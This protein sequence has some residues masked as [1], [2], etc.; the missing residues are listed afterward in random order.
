MA[1]LNVNSDATINGTLTLKDSKGT[2]D[3]NTLLRSISSR[4][5]LAWKFAGSVSNLTA[6]ADVMPIPNG[7]KGY[8]ISEF[9][10][11]TASTTTDNYARRSIVI[12]N[13]YDVIKDGA[14]FKFGTS[15]S[16]I[17]ISLTSSD[18]GSVIRLQGYRINGATVPCKVFVYYR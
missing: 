8:T 12:P 1:A 17:T 9:L 16:E 4:T 2:L 14:V 13:D 18:G 5:L 3:V 10:I 11:I 7:V 15:N 6:P